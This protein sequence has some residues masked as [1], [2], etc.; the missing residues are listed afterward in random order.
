M[1]IGVF[2]KF[3][4]VGGSE[5]RCVEL[6][7]AL[8]RHTSHEAFLF[9][10]GG[11]PS[12]LRSAVLPDVRIYERVFSA[13]EM[14][15]QEL[16][17]LDALLV[18]NTDSKDFCRSAYWRGESSRHSTV[19]N[20]SGVGQLLFL[21]NFIVS[22]A[23]HLWELENLGPRL[24]IITANRKFLD[25]IGD[26]ERYHRVR[27]VPRVTLESPIDPVTV[28]HVKKPS[29]AVRIG[30]YSTSNGDKWNDAWPELIRTVNQRC[31]ESRVRWRLMGMPGPLRSRVA[32]FAN[33][34]ARPEHTQEVGDF[35]AELDIFA[36]FSSWKR[37]EA[38]SRS[39]AEALMSGCPLLATPRGGNRD[40]VVSGNNGLLC[41]DFPAF[42]EGICRLVESEPLRRAMA[43]NA[44]ARAQ[45]FRTEA[46]IGRFLDFLEQ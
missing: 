12:R 29:A 30:M 34:E 35:L 46:V 37:E 43:A 22:P 2:S 23:R 45:A 19:V 4:M 44:V 13:P 14:K 3:E 7:N 8:V 26:Q 33:V 11:L 9:S 25:E 15:P 1:R 42:V 27:H 40:Q 20:L 17:A 24:K 5:K 41:K 31:G 38:W 16:T 39:A 28:S 36:F 10:E 32:E 6:S 18:V 21:F